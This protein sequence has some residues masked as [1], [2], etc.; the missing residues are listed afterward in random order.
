MSARVQ[1]VAFD[2]LETL[3]DLE[4][5]QTRLEEIGQPRQL[6]QPWFMR[7]QRDAL[8]LT[9]AGDVADFHAVAHQAL[10]T[11][12]QQSA[13]AA[14]ID[15]VLEG[16]GV[17]PPHPDAAEAMQRLRTAGVTVGCLTVGSPENTARSLEQAGLASS[18]DHVITTKQAGTWKPAPAVYHVV[19][20]GLDVA[21]EHLALVAVH[22]WDCHGA[23]RAGCLAGWCDRLEGRPGEVFAQADVTGHDL[24]EVADRLIELS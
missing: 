7:F 13:T 18:V 6:F 10:R 12:T 21:P 11:D 1:A 22:A 3:L 14:E 15:Y 2:V 24:V 23:K 5:V 8:A 9:L 4:P 16:F 19:A 17:L 20:E